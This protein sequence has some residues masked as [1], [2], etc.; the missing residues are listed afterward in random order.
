MSND[1]SI[2]VILSQ[3]NV[4]KYEIKNKIVLHLQLLALF[5]GYSSVYS[6]F[7]TNIFNSDGPKAKFIRYLVTSLRLSAS[8]RIRL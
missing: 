6:I 1:S 5:P 4:S 8:D 2:R 3:K 7:V